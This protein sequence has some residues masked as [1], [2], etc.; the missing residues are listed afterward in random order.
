MMR[1]L[2]REHPI[3]SRLVLYALILLIACLFIPSNAMA[4]KPIFVERDVHGYENAYSIPDATTSYAIYG[5]LQ[6]P[7]AVDVYQV[8]IPADTP[9]YA[10]LSVPKKAG[11]DAFQ[12]AF[13]LFGPGLPKSNEPPNYPLAI[14]DG[15]GRATFLFEGGQ[16]QFYEP[17]TQTTLLQR[18]FVSRTLSA[19]MYYIAVYNP[20]GATGKYVL[21]TGT[22]E[23]F[24]ASDWLKFPAT[25]MKVRLWYDAV[26]TWGILLFLL[27]A[28]TALVYV[29]RNR[30]KR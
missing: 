10:R 21:A 15:V 1:T 29:L 8:D 9:F 20:D 23:R 30:K 27:A 24:Q 22:E 19:G 7:R 18:Q 28:L 4:H 6:S 14:P 17:F 25:W 11:A 3:S 13:V 12:P 5:H 26:Q 2:M 16:D